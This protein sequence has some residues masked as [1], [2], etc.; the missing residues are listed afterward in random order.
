MG[1][2]GKPESEWPQ[3]ALGLQSRH[4][5]DRVQGE[6]SGF[7]CPFFADELV[8]REALW[9]LQPSPGFVGADDV[10]EVISHLFLVVVVEAFYDRFLDRAVHAFDP[11]VRPGRSSRGGACSADDRS[12]ARGGCGQRCLR[13][14]EEGV[15]MPFSIAR[16]DIFEGS[17]R[18]GG[19]TM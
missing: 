10:G 18:G 15:N 3:P 14:G 2:Y 9:G 16:Q 12:D 17:P 7:D 19:S 5:M 1:T 6:A 8:G 11:G 13:R 4:L